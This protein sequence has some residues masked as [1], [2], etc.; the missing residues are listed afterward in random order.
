VSSPVWARVDGIADVPIES[1]KAESR[2]QTR[3]RMRR[4]FSTRKGRELS[5]I[6]RLERTRVNALWMSA[7]TADARK[8]NLYAAD[9]SAIAWALTEIWQKDDQFTM[10]QGTP[11]VHD[12]DVDALP[13]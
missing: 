1:L 4:F 6:A 8:S 11:D 10:E 12:V 13:Y 3:E 9:A 2:P 5:I 7:R